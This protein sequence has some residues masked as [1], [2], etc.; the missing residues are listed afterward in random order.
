[1]KV[2]VIGT[3][4]V[5]LVTGSCL[6]ESGNSVICMDIDEG[7]I[8]RLK[9]GDPVIYEP[10]LK[11]LIE[12]NLR[13]GRLEF[14][15]DLRY[16][17]ENSFLLM[18]A[19]PTPE[20][21][22]GS[23]D[24][25]AVL[26]VASSIGEFINDYKIIVTKSTVPVGTTERVRDIIR[27]KTDVE[28][29]VASNPEF[30]KEGSA[31]EDFMKPDRVVI[32]VDKPSVGAILRELYQPF[33]RSGDRAHIISIR[34]SELSKYASNA[35]LA[36]RISFMNEMA[37]LCELLGADVSEVRVV[38]GSDHRI[39]RSFLF[40]GVGYGGSCFPK[41]V[42]ALIHTAKE[43][44]YH[45]RIATATEEVNS[46]QREIFF[47]KLARYFN[48]DL[49]GKRV[50]LWGLSFKPKTN[51]IREAPS[52]YVIDKLLESGA[53]VAVHDPVAIENVRRR[54][55]ERL[56]YVDSSYDACV[57]ADALVILTEWNEYRQPDFEK[58]RSV[59]TGRAV[60]DGRNLY[61]PRKMQKLG[62]DYFAVGLR[63]QST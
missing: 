43:L 61:D 60:F 34:S 31:V 36:C 3:G 54:Y 20:S 50:A 29:D 42:K 37:N 7:K 52:L 11:E 33:M 16:V 39:G 45:L 26:E 9:K 58:I 12:N 46:V 38:M 51:D 63:C 1:M 14:T 6:A 18:I 13:H 19:V 40:P 48:F 41:D 22:D 47:T 59:M 30:L 27:E 44:G 62:F 35:M 24:L 8:E 4:Y 15:T 17:V 2:G 10:G 55:G 21:G 5:G 28:F 25:S 23:A 53:S 57:G 49:K 32:G 56:H